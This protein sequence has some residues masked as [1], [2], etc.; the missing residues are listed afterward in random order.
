M[1]LDPR[2]TGSNLAKGDGLLS[3]IKI[4]STISI[5][6]EVKPFVPFHQILWL[7]KV[8]YKYKKRY[9]VCKIHGH[10]WPHFS[11]FATRTPSSK[12]GEMW[13]KMAVNFAGN[14]Q[15]ALVGKSGMIRTQ[16]GDAQ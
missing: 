8:P 14:F 13:P 10:F 7:V 2:S 6:G 15:R 1:P 4:H 11:S 5:R 16:M 12:G 9:F 3:M